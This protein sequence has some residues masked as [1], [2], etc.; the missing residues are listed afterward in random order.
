MGGKANGVGLN[1][2]GT[3]PTPQQYYDFINSEGF[4]DFSDSS[5][6]ALNNYLLAYNTNTTNREL[7]EEANAH[8][9][10][11]W[12]LSN[13][14]NTPANQMKRMLEAGLNPAAAYGQVDAGNASGSP[15]THQSTAQMPHATEFRDS[16]QKMQMA[17]LIL[18]GVKD[19]VGS[20]N[21]TI[22]TLYGLPQKQY[23]GE[24]A[25][26]DSKIAQESYAAILGQP[27][28]IA[29]EGTP[30]YEALKDRP[31]AYMYPLGDGWYADET[32]LHNPLQLKYTN[33]FMKFITSKNTYDWYD[34]YRQHMRNMFS[35]EEAEMQYNREMK[36]WLD[37]YKNTLPPQFRYIIDMVMQV[38]GAASP[39]LQN[40]QNSRINPR[41]STIYRNTYNVIK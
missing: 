29:H 18:N 27:L 19:F 7:A 4:K 3:S 11:M 6:T 17:Q 24:A 34:S 31:G 32:A 9:L 39:F 13:E 5:K 38:F 2:L 35:D 28:Y 8:E 30:Y 16:Q 36:K 1:T 25:K 33:E 10:D 40:W 12:K 23:A 15:G 37:D 22:N 26:W 41:Q 14:Y 20:F 21:D